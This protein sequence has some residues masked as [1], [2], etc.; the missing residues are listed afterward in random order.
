MGGSKSSTTTQVRNDITVNPVTNV[1][2]NTDEIAKIMQEQLTLEETQIAL[3]T[4]GLSLE[5]QKLNLEEKSKALDF[6]NSEKTRSQITF[7]ALLG[8]GYYFYKKLKRR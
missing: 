8:G 5:Q 6:L 7:L 1:E 4:A 2:L 3:A